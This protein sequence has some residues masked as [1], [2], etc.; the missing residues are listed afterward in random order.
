MPWEWLGSS[1]VVGFTRVCTGNRWVHP[2]SLGSLG[3]ALGV[4]CFIRGS[5]DHSCAPKGSLGSLAHSL[6]VVGLMRDLWVHSRLPLG[7]LDTLGVVE[8]THARPVLIGSAVVVVFIGARPG[9][10]WVHTGLLVSDG[11][12][13]S[14]APCGLLGSSR[15]VGFAQVRPWGRCVHRGSFCSLR[16]GVVGFITCR[17]VCLALPLE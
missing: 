12:V 5:R 8:F 2:V 1:G 11:W 16:C 15:V 10:R 9:G 7:S 4:V 17:L 6:G 13:H 3:C 14:R